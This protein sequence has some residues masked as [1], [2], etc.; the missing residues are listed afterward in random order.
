MTG[1]IGEQGQDG[2]DIQ[3][4]TGKPGQ[5]SRDKTEKESWPEH[6]SLGQDNRDR[7]NA[8]GQAGLNSWDR[9]A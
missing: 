6:D 4:G 5:D 3:V 2:G 1:E 8:A 9:I 7:T